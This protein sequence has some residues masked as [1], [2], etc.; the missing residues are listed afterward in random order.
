MLSISSRRS[1]FIEGMIGQKAFWPACLFASVL[2]SCSPSKSE[3]PSDHK[4]LEL[5]LEQ[6]RSGDMSLAEA[7]CQQEGGG[8]LSSREICSDF[9]L[10]VRSSDEAA[11]RSE[12]AARLSV[13]SGLANSSSAKLV[14]EQAAA[15]YLSDHPEMYRAALRAAVYALR[16]SHLI[17][18]GDNSI[19]EK[20]DRL[21]C[22]GC[23]SLR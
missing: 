8:W 12:L 19:E 17:N 9:F 18:S 2:L 21:L 11:Q 1:G 6:I 14:A 10:A 22:A 16:N 4:R 13:L 15:T 5:L 23:V 3:G 7:A 20:I